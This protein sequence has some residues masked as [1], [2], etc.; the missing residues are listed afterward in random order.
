MTSARLL[1][2][3]DLMFPCLLQGPAEAEAE[4]EGGT[5]TSSEGGSPAYMISARM[6]FQSSVFCDEADQIVKL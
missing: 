5:Q 1:S 6:N 2:P 4:A 3:L